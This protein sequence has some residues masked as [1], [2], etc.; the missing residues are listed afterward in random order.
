MSPD[1]ENLLKIAVTIAIISFVMGI[2]ICSCEHSI[3]AKREWLEHY[4]KWH[5]KP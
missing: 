2:A 5:A 4:E 3:D 1:T